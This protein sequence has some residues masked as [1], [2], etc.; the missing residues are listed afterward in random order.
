MPYECSS[1]VA[2]NNAAVAKKNEEYFN[3]KYNQRSTS[4]LGE[5]ANESGAAAKTQTKRGTKI[6]EYG[7]T[8]MGKDS[9]LKLL[10][11]QMQN[12][13]PTQNQDSTAYITQMA[14]LSSIEQ[15]HN[16]NNTMTGYSVRNLLGQTAQVNMADEKGNYIQGTVLGTYIKGDKQYLSILNTA[17]GKVYDYIDSAKVTAVVKNT[18]ADT[19]LSAL[20][21]QFI[22]A[23]SLK[24]KYIIDAVVGEDEKTITLTKGK[25]TGAYLDSD[26]IKL[27]ITKLDD[28]L[29]EIGTAEVNYLDV[30]KMGDLTEEELK[31]AKPEDF[32]YLLGTSSDDDSSKENKNSDTG[33]D[34]NIGVS[35]GYV[36]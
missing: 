35:S 4:S 26:G 5:Q 15:M 22:A 28:D 2:E 36:R 7:D 1:K 23:S 9:F 29:N 11:A 34:S 30:D 21:T 10:V 20:N 27:K 33:E 17:D 24:G 12:M 13:D 32:K 16:L 25:V 6:T 14:Q 31:K 18:S 3:K 8:G 19:Y